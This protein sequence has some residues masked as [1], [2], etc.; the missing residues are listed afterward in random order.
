MKLISF[1]TNPPT[2]ILSSKNVVNMI[3]RS[4]MILYLHFLPITRICEA[5]IRHGTKILFLCDEKGT[6]FVTG[7]THS[8]FILML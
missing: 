7:Y 8:L 5:S 2:Q 3:C 6:G 4:D 1:F